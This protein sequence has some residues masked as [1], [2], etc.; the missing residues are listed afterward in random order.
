MIDRIVIENF[1]SLR[2][3]DLKV[4]RLNLL[5]GA[6]GSG[7]S[8]LLNALRVLQGVGHGFTIREILDGK[9]EDAT[10]AKW[11]AI[12]GGSRYAC[13]TVPG[14]DDGPSD[15][16]IEVHGRIAGGPEA[17]WVGMEKR[18]PDGQPA[19]PWKLR[20]AFSPKWGR[21]TRECFTVDEV[22]YDTDD[23]TPHTPNDS[24]PLA[25][26]PLR[27]AEGWS[28]PWDRERPLLG[29]L[30]RGTRQRGIGAPGS[31]G[32]L[33]TLKESADVYSSYAD[34][35]RGV[36]ALLANIRRIEPDLRFLR[37]Y[38]RVSEV[39]RL[40]DRGEN[41]AAMIQAICRN[42]EVKDVYLSWLRE[43]RP[44]QIDDVGVLVGAVGEPLFMLQEHGRELPATVLSAGTLRFA[45]VAAAFFQP[46]MPSLMTLEEIE[47]GIHAN[48]MRTLLELL[49]TQ[50]EATNTQ[51]IATT[52][53]ATVLDWLAGEDYETTFLCARD[54]ETGESHIRALAEVPHF[55]DVVKKTPAS[56]LFA[57]GWLEAAR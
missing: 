53:S 8:N 3:V 50:A 52:H 23:A 4:G 32:D 31:A 37:D 40:G 15:V 47:N 24:R 10:K 39:R 35:A 14:S 28:V 57:E 20:I 30:A 22:A 45:A 11:E 34:H 29:Q 7:K 51:V 2:R 42:Q 12:R 1:K 55:L 49:R 5:V 54:E 46:D 19:L 18:T 56:E 43:L 6:N 44:E 21:V 17:E 41:F 25:T 36:A 27:V 9:P 16:Q 33:R 48:R 26:C 38:A 13:F